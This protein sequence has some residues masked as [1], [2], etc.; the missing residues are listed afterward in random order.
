MIAS[1]QGEPGISNI[2]S[3]GEPGP[4]GYRGPPGPI[5]DATGKQVVTLKGEKVR[6]LYQQLFDKCVTFYCIRD[7]LLRFCLDGSTS[8]DSLLRIA[9]DCYIMA[10]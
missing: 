4:M 3:P 10:N 9:V 1:F 2:G 6:R 5:I 8:I 7:V